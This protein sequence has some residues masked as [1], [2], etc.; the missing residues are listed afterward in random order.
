MKA[1][2]EAMYPLLFVGHGAPTV[3]LSSDAYTEALASLPARLPRPAALVVVSAHWQVTGPARVTAAEDPGLLY[4]FYGFPSELYE[5]TY[6]CPGSATLAREIVASLADGGRP[7]AAEPVRGLDHGV[8]IPLLLAWPSADIP[9]VQVS[10]PLGAA[11]RELLDLGLALAP[12]RLRGV[13][14]VGSGNVVHNM[15]TLDW[16]EKDAPPVQWAV[17]FDEWV[18]DAVAAHDV[19][20]LCAYQELAPRADLAVPTTEH[21]DPLLVVAGAMAPSDR[22]EVLFDGYHHGTLAM[23][24]FLLR[25]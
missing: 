20:A 25:G 7:A 2:G 18:R 17:A 3:A 9:V 4:D 14:V 1:R 6:P 21:F 10:L 24:T 5:L 13:L 19:D 16:E 11:P 23:R 22:V 15:R 12:L 8:W